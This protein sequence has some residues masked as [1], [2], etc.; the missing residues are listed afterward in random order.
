MAQT[1]QTLLLV[2]GMHRSGTSALTRVLNLLGAQLPAQLMPPVEGNNALGFWEPQSLYRLNDAVLQA[3]GSRWDDWRPL[4]PTALR[5]L[6][7]GEL[8]ARAREQLQADFGEAPLGVLK[9]PRLSRLLPFWQPIFATLDIDLRGVLITRNPLEVAASLQA[10]DGFSAAQSL[11]LW[12]RYVLDAEHDSRELP[13]VLLP[14]TALLDD[15]QSAVARIGSRT[16]LQWPRTAEVAAAD[17]EAFLRADERHHQTEAESLTRQALTRGWVQDTDTAL[18]RLC[19]AEDPAAAADAQ[20]ALERIAGEVARAAELWVPLLDERR[21]QADAE[22]TQAR[23]EAQQAHARQQALEQDLARDRAQVQALQARERQLQTQLDAEQAAHAQSRQEHAQVAAQL[24]RRETQLRLARAQAARQLRAA[25]IPNVNGARPVRLGRHAAHL[26]QA[27]RLLR[28][29]LFDASWYATEYKLRGRPLALALHWLAQGWRQGQAPHPGFALDWYLRAYPDVAQAGVQPLWHYLEHGEA[30][31]RQPSPYFQPAWYLH[32]HPDVAAAGLGAW[33]H[34]CAYGAAEG[35]RPNPYFEPEF[36]LAGSDE[37]APAQA[38]ADYRRVAPLAAKAPSPWFDAAWYLQR[39]PDVEAGGLDPLWHYLC[40][41]A[42][43]G[44]APNPGFDAGWYRERCPGLDPQADAFAHWLTQGAAAGLAPHPH[45]DARA[46]AQRQPELPTEPTA[47]L[48]HWLSRPADRR[49][50]LGAEAGPPALASAAGRRPPRRPRVDSAPPQVPSAAERQA[51]LAAV[52]GASAPRFSVVMPTWNRAE[53]VLEAIASVQAQSYPHWEL[54]LCDDGSEDDTLARVRARYPELVQSG[55]LRLLALPHAGVSA[56]RNSGL[57]AATGDCIAYLDS[58]NRWHP[59]YLLH[60]AAAYIEDPLLQT[61]YAAL[62]VDDQARGRRFERGRDFDWQ[63]LRAQNYID[64]NIFSHRRRVHAQLGGFDTGLRRLV[65]WD[66]ILR[67]TRLYEPRYLP[68]L[69]ADYRIAPALENITLTEDLGRNEAAVRRKF[70]RI[71]VEDPAAL[72]LAYVIWDWPALS[73]TFVMEELR[74]LLRR[75]IDVRVYY[76]QPPDRAAQD[77]PAVVATRVADA[78]D[79]AARL[80]ADE[81]TWVHGHFAY[82]GGTLLLWP[83]AEACGLPF[84]LMPHAVDIFHHANR[85]RNR[86]AEIAASPYCA[87]ILVHGPHHRDFLQSQGVPAER[88]IYT[89]QA[90]SLAPT[91]PTAAR[92]D[93][94]GPRRILCATRLVEKKGVQLLL[95]ALAQLPAE[96]AEL[97]IAGYGPLE[98][99]LRARSHELGVAERVH[100][101]GGYEGAAELQA[102]LAQADVFCLPC[103]EAE[104]GD[105]DGLPTVLLE[106]MAAGV[107][108]LT[109]AVSAIPD[110]LSDGIQAFVSAAEPAALAAGLRDVLQLPAAQRQAISAQGQAWCQREFGSARPVDTLLDLALAPPLDIF[111]VTFHR[112]G[113]GNWEAT[114]RAIDSVRAHTQTPF[115]LTIVDNASDADFLERLEA[116]IAADDR[117]RL[118]ALPENRYCGPASN[119]ALERARSE[120]IIYVCSNEGLILH[121]GWERKLLHH[122]RREPDI[123]LGGQLVASPAWPDGRAYSEQSWF[124][125]FRAQ[126]FARAHPER[127]FRHVQGGLFV[128]RRSVYEEHGGFSPQRPQALMDVEYSYYLESQSLRLGELPGLAALSN[129]TRPGLDSFVDEGTLAAHPVFEE[130]LPLLAHCQGDNA[131]RCNLCGWT[132]EI[133]RAADRISFDCPDCGSRPFDRAVYRQ[134]ATSALHHRGLRLDPRGLGARARAVLGERMFALVAD[135]AAADV[136]AEAQLRGAPSRVLGLPP[137]LLRPA[138]APEPVAGAGSAPRGAE[139]GEN[140]AS[141]PGTPQPDAAADTA[142]AASACNICGHREFGPG[143]GGRRAVGGEAWPRC[144]RCQS[145]ERHRAFR[146]AFLDIGEAELAGRN[147]ALQFSAD[148]AVPREW[149]AGLEVSQYGGD[150]SLDLM[151]IDR[152]DGAYQLVICNHVLE[153]VPDDRSALQELGR[154]TAAEGLV[155]LSFPD[156]LRRETTVDWGYA[157]E[158][159]HG[160][161]RHYGRDVYALLREALP[162]MH[163]LNAVGTDPAT[164][165][166]EMYFLL[167]RQ[168]QRARHWLQALPSAQRI[169]EPALSEA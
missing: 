57:E 86:I 134:L 41:G 70:A 141:N 103:I 13:R 126:D 69:L 153:H 96:A 38:L 122:M 48:R 168:A 7:E 124:A 18:A 100:F 72:R 74:E 80:R 121:A 32:A 118:L 25:T 3:M 89:P 119:L 105:R 79:L 60:V 167:T 30:E 22:R 10:R 52:S 143:P 155:F 77:L 88:C 53:P 137:H 46:Y 42:A 5:E 152:A 4:D 161:Y 51:A 98:A 157:D 142:T 112:E 43:E 83:A 75:G 114:E 95:E 71:S 39:Y 12:L 26:R 113:Y 125:D 128:L 49:P 145:L 92:K 158:S 94:D 129:K 140:A 16:G 116:H 14:Y 146:Q 21:A 156:P 9:E 62:R 163:I 28:E 101:S 40:H 90:V 85:Q 120:F 136:R 6:A 31:G 36:Y 132:G 47:A 11:L 24:Q 106:A 1:R 154:I 23:S 127:E 76:S 150:N 91:P 123:A 144:T 68:L 117:I 159:R 78:E 67:Y 110:Y 54:L 29:R 66:L 65:D 148:P 59:D 104:N 149:F 64:L 107:P 63:D 84:S 87:G 56:A 115:R 99:K 160:H 147:P 133:A 2:L 27:R 169:H 164:G 20:A 138:A 108:V 162:E 81:R 166:A 102:L 82:P 61:C 50:P 35:R 131:A 33:A 109:T 97:Q 93:G 45:F 58:D 165:C 8:G 135:G 17:I 151:Q 37:L 55:Q 19:A 44:R 15:W 130:T 111:M 73:Q 34:Y 139:A